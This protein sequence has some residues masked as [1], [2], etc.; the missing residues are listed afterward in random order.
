MIALRARAR[1]RESTTEP[2]GGPTSC[3]S[4]ESHRGRG[5]TR[6]RRRRRASFKPRKG[7]R[8]GDV[9]IDVNGWT[10]YAGGRWDKCRT[11]GKTRLRHWPRAGGESGGA[12]KAPPDTQNGPSSKACLRS[13]GVKY[14][15]AVTLMP[16][17]SVAWV[18][19]VVL[20]GERL[21]YFRRESAHKST[22]LTSSH[23][24]ESG[25]ARATTY[26]QQMFHSVNA[27]GAGHSAIHNIN[28]T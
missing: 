16:V 1:A 11:G 21:P 3:R 4:L 25:Q 13:T 9:T 24:A 26:I 8:T 27:W 15:Q 22:L 6:R 17:R 12:R 18:A 7:T 28:I 14:A 2:V 23:P 5:Q 20:S 19:R 10:S